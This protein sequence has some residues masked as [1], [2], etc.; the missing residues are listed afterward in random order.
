M[1]RI[2]K[3]SDYG[4]VVMTYLAQHP[5]ELHAARDITQHINLALPTVTKI[6][7]IFARNGLLISQRG[8]SGG[9][10][11]ARPSKD[12]ALSEIIQA[13]EGELGLTECSSKD[14]HCVLESTCSTRKNWRLISQLMLTAL[15]N[16]TLEEMA[17][18]L[19]SEHFLSKLRAPLEHS[20][21]PMSENHNES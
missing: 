18:S 17:T 20:V 15:G 4:M 1:F 13:V 19:T 2:S 14:C 9:Y 10:I 7:K 12:I 21:Q 16:I 5:E 6:L 3:L 11:L 8:A